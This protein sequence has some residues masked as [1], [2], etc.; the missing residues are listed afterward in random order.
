MN[1]R[2]VRIPILDLGCPGDMVRLERRLARQAGVL[3]VAVNP[4]TEAIYIRFDPRSTTPPRLR[5]AVE[6]EGYRT[7]EPVV[8]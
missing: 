7:A 3:E 5:N 8:G 2:W 6:H 1:E 4:A